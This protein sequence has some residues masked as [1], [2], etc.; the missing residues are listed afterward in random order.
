MNQTE[1]RLQ[2]TPAPA[3]TSHRGQFLLTH[4]SIENVSARI[5]PGDSPFFGFNGSQHPVS[6]ILPVIGR[7]GRRQ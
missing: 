7:Q 5:V 2:V 1:K 4:F 3:A 6:R